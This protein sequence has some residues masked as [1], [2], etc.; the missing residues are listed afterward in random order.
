[1]VEKKQVHLSAMFEDTRGYR[2]NDVKCQADSD[3]LW[4]TV[5]VNT[6]LAAC[7]ASSWTMAVKTLGDRAVGKTTAVSIDLN[8]CWWVESTFW[9]FLGCFG[10]LKSYS[11]HMYIYIY[12]FIIRVNQIHYLIMFGAQ[13]I[14][15]TGCKMTDWKNKAD[16]CRTSQ[17]MTFFSG[18]ISPISHLLFLGWW[19]KWGKETIIF[20][21]CIGLRIVRGN[22]DEEWHWKE[23]PCMCVNIYIYIHCSISLVVSRI[24]YLFSAIDGFLFLAKRLRRTSSCFKHVPTK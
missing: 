1:M 3:S 20:W 21:S 23:A 7:R 2:F 14:L 8:G 4:G 19:H 13:K 16:F 15:T 11:I 24:L 22:N 17:Y 12:L 6:V 5:T 9:V 18:G 10:L